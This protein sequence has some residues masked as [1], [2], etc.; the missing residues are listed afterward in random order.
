SEIDRLAQLM[1]DLLDYGR[2]REDALSPGSLAEVVA[3]AA[4]SCVGLAEQASVRI[5]NTVSAGAARMDPA[6]LVRVF[7]NLIENAVQHSHPGAAVRLTGARL[8]NEIWVWVLDSGPGF[9]PQDLPQVWKPFFTRRRGGTGLGLSIV[10]RIVEQHG[11]RVAVRN[12]K[13]GGAAVQVTL[14]ACE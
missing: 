6:R 8:G 13:E 1:A 5:E 14:P 2:P 9:A 11:G 3:S 7:Q 4:R 12:R 10:Q